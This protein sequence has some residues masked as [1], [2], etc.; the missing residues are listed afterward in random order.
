MSSFVLKLVFYPVYRLSDMYMLFTVFETRHMH[1][2][3]TSKFDMTVRV[4]VIALQLLS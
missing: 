3:L 4:A 2:Y 1:V